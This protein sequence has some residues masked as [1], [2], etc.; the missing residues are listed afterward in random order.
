VKLKL[1]PLA[2]QIAGRR[3]VLFDD[4]I[5]RGTT[6]RRIISILKDAGAREVHMRVGCPPIKSPCKL[7]IDM[8]TH[9]E[10]IASSRSVEEIRRAIGAD[11]LK[12][13]RIEDLIAAIGLSEDRLC[14]GCL[15]GRY[16]VEIAR[17]E[18]LRLPVYLK[19]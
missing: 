3:V 16:P 14:L 2:K 12:Y 15:T 19:K 6:S 9:E 13:T 17:Y 18:Q 10:L 1:N 7:G 5:V 4:S 11:S 8:P